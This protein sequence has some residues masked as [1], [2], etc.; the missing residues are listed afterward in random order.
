MFVT[1]QVVITALM[2]G[3]FFWNRQKYMLMNIGKWTIGVNERSNSMDFVA[4]MNSIF[5]VV[6]EQEKTIHVHEHLEVNCMCS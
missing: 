1:T 6:H 2:N 3:I 4:F 5:F